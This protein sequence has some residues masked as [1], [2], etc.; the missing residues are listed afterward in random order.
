MKY[1]LTCLTPL[2]VGYGSRLSPIDYMVWRDRVN[3]LDQRKIFRLLAK[4]PRL[5]GYLAQ[6]KKAQKLD[7]ASWGGFAQNF[8]DRRIPFEHPSCTAAWERAQGDSLFIPT[9]ASG[10]HGL[11]LPGSA[12]KGALRSG[13]VFALWKDGVPEPALA[14]FQSDR[15]PRCPALAGEEQVLGAGGWDRTR[16]YQVR[17]SQPV[18]PSVTKVYLLRVATILSRTPGRL[19]LGWKAAPR[20]TVDA[21][22]R[23]T[24][25]PLFAEMVCPGTAFEGEWRENEFLRHPEVRKDLRWSKLESREDLFRNANLF[26]ARLLSLHRHFAETTSLDLLSVNLRKLESRLEQAAGSNTAC[27]LSMGWGGGLLGKS[28][29]AEPDSATFRRIFRDMPLYSRALSSGLPFPK[30]RKVVFLDGQPASLPGWVLLE[31]AE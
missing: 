5:E 7:F 22:Q 31:V 19:E 29:I 27:V 1:R 28:A 17:D 13:T 10:P 20:G 4:G 21:R 16:W 11:Y 2:L 24:S 14:R 6:L 15:A 25:N 8:A 30:T 26:S 3:V 9:F 12:A 23:D 18:D